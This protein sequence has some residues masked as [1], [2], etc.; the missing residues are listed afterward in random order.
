MKYVIMQFPP[1]SGYLLSL[2]TQH[3]VL[4][5]DPSKARCRSLDEMHMVL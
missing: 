5:T 1:F 2:H 4:N 3:P